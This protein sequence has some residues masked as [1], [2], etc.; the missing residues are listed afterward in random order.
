MA[1]HAR[2]VQGIKESAGL[3]RSVKLDRSAIAK[4]LLKNMRLA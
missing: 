3:L 1:P 2:Q 4:F